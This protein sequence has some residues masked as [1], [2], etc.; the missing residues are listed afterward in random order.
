MIHTGI[1]NMMQYSLHY[2]EAPHEPC[3]HQKYDHRCGKGPSIDK[4]ATPPT[5]KCEQVP[6]SKRPRVAFRSNGKYD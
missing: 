1:R 3:T 5:A 6:A 2:V 4:V